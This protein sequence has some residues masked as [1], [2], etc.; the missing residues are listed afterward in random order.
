MKACLMCNRELPINLTLKQ[1]FCLQA[2]QVPLICE[3]CRQTFRPIAKGTACPGCS[4]PQSTAQDCND[5][6]RWKAQVAE[7][8]VSHEALFYYDEALKYWLQRYK[9][10]GD[11][12]FAQI[13]SAA[14]KAH[15]KKS[16]EAII[17]PIPVSES[18]YV[19][20]GFNQCE[21]LLRVADVPYEKWLENVSI[22]KKQSEKNRKERLQTA[23]PF[24]IHSSFEYKVPMIILFDDVYTT[25]RTLM[26]AKQLFAQAGMTNISS[27]SIGR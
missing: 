20:R 8:L 13:M 23:Q 14:I 27:F 10:Q 5:C 12:R 7:N 17:V 21:E 26:H 24:H 2:Y 11:T 3:R 25:G 22:E 6:K 1:I 18:S 19:K 9:F 16:P 15:V 4:R